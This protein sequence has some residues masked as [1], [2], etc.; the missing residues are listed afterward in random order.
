MKTRFVLPLLFLSAA[1]HG[2]I[3]RAQSPGTFSLTGN[4]TTPRFG[5]TATL[6][7]NGK[8]LI[9]GGVREFQGS[10]L[11]I[12]ASAE[13]YDPSTGAFTATG[14]MTTPR[15][16]HTATLLPDGRVLIAGGVPFF[17]PDLILASAELYDPSTGAFTATGDMTTARAWQ[18]ATL[19]T[20]GKVLIAGGTAPVAELYDPATGTFSPTG[21]YSS[22]PADFNSPQGATSTLLQDGRVLIVWEYPALGALDQGGP[23]AELYDPDSDTFTAT[24]TSALWGYI[25]LPTATL[26]MNGKVLVAGG[27]AE[28]VNTGAELYDSSTGTFTATANMITGRAFHTDTLLPDGR[29]LLA[30]GLL[31]GSGDLAN[32]ELY[33]PVTGAFAATGNMTRARSFH[34]ATLLN[35]GRVLI[36]GGFSPSTTITS[37]AE[38]YHPVVLVPAPQLFSVSGDG[39]GQGAILHGSTHQVVSPG[40]PAVA[41]EA[42]EIYLTGL[43]DGSVIP[44]QVAIG[45]RLAEILYFGNA[46]G[47][48]GLNQVNVRVPSNVTPGAG[49]PVRLTYIGRPSNAVTIGVQ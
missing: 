26:L 49:V 1:G 2:A 14:N 7:T 28:V 31:F 38:I 46:P 43:T 37:I 15:T 27:A 42:L 19:L 22:W 6:L 17:V 4:M 8:V 48:T 29:V 18:A 32:V 20:S 5:H 23:A 3:A 45:G 9:A 44:P 40:N 33:S 24:G 34:T 12:L 41:G 35:D 39:Q 11:V 10:S 13:L 25:V 16:S 36:T 47:F 21:K 30:G